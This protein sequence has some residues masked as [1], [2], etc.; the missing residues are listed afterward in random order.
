MQLVVCRRTRGGLVFADFFIFF[1]LFF[2]SILA[3]V[4]TNSV[5]IAAVI[6]LNL[7]SAPTPA[8]SN[9]IVE[10]RRCSVQF[11]WNGIPRQM[12]SSGVSCFAPRQ[13]KVTVKSNLIWIGS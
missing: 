1:F 12:R 7:F 11:Q 4:C 9:N 13:C 10:G 5:G 2:S 8:P 3:M 6:W